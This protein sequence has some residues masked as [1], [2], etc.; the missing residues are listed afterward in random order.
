MAETSGLVQESILQA[1]MRG[2]RLI[3]IV[4]LI[5]IP[6]LLFLAVFVFYREAERNGFIYAL[7]NSAFVV[8]LIALL[9]ATAYSFWQLNRI[10]RRHYHNFMKYVSPFIE[11]TLLSIIHYVNAAP[12]RNALIITGSPTFLYFVFI[13]LCA[14][15]NSPGSVVFTGIYAAV[16]YAALS[17]NALAVLK[18][19]EGDGVQFT[20]SFS[21]II[22]LDWD[23]EMIKPL[24]FIMSTI[25]LAY[26]AHRFN[27]TVTDQIRTSAEREDLKGVLVEN[28]RQ[29]SQNLI[30]S[31]KSLVVTYGE[32]SR[33]IEQLVGSSRRIGEETAEEYGVIEATTRTVGDMIGSIGTVTGSI[34]E[35]AFL[36][37][38]T[39]AAIAEME[40]SIRTISETSQRANAVAQ[41][42][43]NAA[44]EGET[45]VA[46]VCNAILDTE[47]Y[48]RQIEEIVEL[49]TGIAGRTDL[50]SM[51]AAI[52]AAHAGDAG[53]GFAVVADEIRRLSETSGSNAKQIG[54]I[55]KD[56][57]VR[58][59][60]STALAQRASIKLQSILND[61][62]MTKGINSTIQ[63]AMEEEVKT[64]NA[65]VKS[66]T[67]LEAITSSVKESSLRQSDAGSG[68]TASI[69]KLKKEADTVSGL[70]EHQQSE[71]GGIVKLTASFD[72][73]VKNNDAIVEQLEGLIRKV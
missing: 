62:D 41:N 54:D 21:Q 67:S 55:L 6:I 49:I 69:T 40:G 65:I 70:I 8:Q 61:A 4:R 5:I 60:N 16:C 58:I 1:R 15:R 66:L 37:G 24:S 9:V 29:V 7:R 14:L 47:R 13:I 45:A 72:S 25:L 56:I 44:K 39:A 23:D 26:L 17:F 73:V 59:Q 10:K 20:N 18:V 11:I 46:E 22:R 12:P 31:G 3:A 64:V 52:E 19:F 63:T 42:L 27:K 34:K 2:E 28:V 36:V 43:F 48:S 57:I 30:A 35:Q 38:E 33:R 53:R 32:F 50:L 71:C 51:N 68:L